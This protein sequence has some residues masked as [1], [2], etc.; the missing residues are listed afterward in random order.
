MSHSRMVQTRRRKQVG[1]KILARE[2]KQIKKLTKKDAKPAE[3]AQAA[4]P[5]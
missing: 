4:R 5:E 2:A 1:K 3:A